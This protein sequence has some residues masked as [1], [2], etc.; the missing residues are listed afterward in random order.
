MIFDSIRHIETK[1]IYLGTLEVLH[2]ERM[3]CLAT[4]LRQGRKETVM[5]FKF[6]A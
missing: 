1:K 5:Q 4:Q 2:K 6:A 3:L